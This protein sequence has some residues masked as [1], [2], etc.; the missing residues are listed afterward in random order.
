MQVKHAFEYPG[1]LHFNILNIDNI[2]QYSINIK[3]TSVL[4][5]VVVTNR[6]IESIVMQQSSQ[7]YSM[8]NCLWG[9]GVSSWAML[10]SLLQ[11]HQYHS[12]FSP[13]L[14]SL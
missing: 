12:T 13:N 5:M 9:L 3:L 14:Q 10:L 11:A 8:V 1:I 2:S 7:S 4:Q 6:K